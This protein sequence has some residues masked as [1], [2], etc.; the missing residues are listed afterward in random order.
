MMGLINYYKGDDAAA[1]EYILTAK[2]NGAKIHPKIES[3]LLNSDSESQEED[4]KLET[5]EDYEMYETAFINGA[6]WLVETPVDK[7]VEQ[8]MEINS[9]LLQ[10]MTG[11]PYVSIAIEEAIVP[12]VG[13]CADC[14]MVFMSGWTRY[15]LETKDYDNK[16]KGTLVGTE[17]VIEFYQSNK[18]ALGK[19]K[20]IDNFIKL[21]KKR[22]L[23]DYIRENM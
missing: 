21:K 4:F 15:A 11:S 12:Y 16:F 10:W 22:K 13:D 18:R 2:E 20:A 9:F 23:E 3:D 14:L 6:K 8:R 17:R 1:K 19:I 5:K 7:E